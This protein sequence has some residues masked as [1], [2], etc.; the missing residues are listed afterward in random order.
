MSHFQ[1]DE[2]LRPAL[3]HGV[4]LQEDILVLF[5]KANIEEAGAKVEI[6]YSTSDSKK[7]TS[8]TYFRRTWWFLPYILIKFQISQKY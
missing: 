4:L 2:E 8:L 7:K 6:Q 1:M 5:V 3:K